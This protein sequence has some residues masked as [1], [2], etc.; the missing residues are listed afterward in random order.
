[1]DRAFANRG[2]SSGPIMVLSIIAAYNYAIPRFAGQPVHPDRGAAVGMAFS[3]AGHPNTFAGRLNICS[4]RQHGVTA[5]AIHNSIAPHAGAARRLCPI[6]TNNNLQLT[7]ALYAFSCV[8]RKRRIRSTVNYVGASGH[9]IHLRL[10]SGRSDNLL[11]TSCPHRLTP[12]RATR[13]GLV[14]LGPRNT[15]HCNSLHSTLRIQTS[16]HNGKALVITRNVNVSGSPTSTQ[17]A[18]GI[19]VARGVVGFN[20]MGRGTPRRRHAFALAG[21]NSN[22][23][24]IH[25]IRANNGITAALAP[26][27]HV[28]TNDSF[29][30][31]TALSP[32]E[33]RC[34]MIASFIAVVAGSPAHP[35]QQLQTA[36]VIRSW[37]CSGT[38]LPHEQVGT[39]GPFVGMPS[40]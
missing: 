36:T 1:M 14:C 9:P 33:R 35:V 37:E 5:L 3:P 4:S 27:R 28:P 34:N 19:R 2:H 10:R 25:T 23:L 7:S 18:P 21:A 32:N 38:T 29:A 22:R 24:V 40:A 8:H 39:K 16:N 30:T 15:P 20:P 11:T 26:K 13:V 12:N 17:Q 31:G 6:S